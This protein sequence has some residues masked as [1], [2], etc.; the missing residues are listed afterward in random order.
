MTPFPRLGLPTGL[1]QSSNQPAASGPPPID[2][3]M[4]TIVE[5]HEA[6]KVS[7]Q[8]MLD[9]QDRFKTNPNWCLKA[10][11]IYGQL[12]H[13]QCHLDKALD[14]TGH[15]VAGES[16]PDSVDTVALEGFG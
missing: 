11:R 13:L 12:T 10:S 16:H 7:R 4:R 14:P 15:M 1:I 8:T 5:L 3:T 6:L 9:F 2:T